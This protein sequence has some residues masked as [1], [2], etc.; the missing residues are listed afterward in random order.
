MK[1]ARGI[2][3]EIID[4]FGVEESALLELVK[5]AAESVLVTLSWSLP[6]LETAVLLCGDARI[7]E[8]NQEFRGRDEPTDVLSFPLLVDA[9]IAD[10]QA[11]RL[12]YGYPDDTAAVTLGDVVVNIAEAQRAARRYGH[13]LQRELA[14]LVVHGLLHLLGFDHDHAGAEREMQQ[15]AEAALTRLG[16][17]RSEE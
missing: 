1:A 5:A 4:E 17:S 14:F 7:Q 10:L 15:A 13:S 2:D 16:L 11:G 9:E 6:R 3:V 8:L 12:P